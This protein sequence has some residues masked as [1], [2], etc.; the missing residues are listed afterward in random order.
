M[1]PCPRSGL[2]EWLVSIKRTPQESA[3]ELQDVVGHKFFPIGIDFG[4]LV[5]QFHQLRVA[6]EDAFVRPEYERVNHSET[7][8]LWQRGI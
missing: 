8:L 6:S 3:N 7:G 5:G 1:L 2:P 4:K